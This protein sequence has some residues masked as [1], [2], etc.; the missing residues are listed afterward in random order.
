M[1]HAAQYLPVDPMPLDHQAGC[2]CSISIQGRY[3]KTSTGLLISGP[4]G[5]CIFKTLLEV[6]AQLSLDK[7][8]KRTYAVS[9]VSLL[10]FGLLLNFHFFPSWL[11]YVFYIEVALFGLITTSQFW[12][13]ANLVFSSLEAK[14][15]FGF[16]GAGAIAGGISGGYSPL[17][18]SIFSIVFTFSLLLPP[19]SLSILR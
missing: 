1:V 15:L 19:S 4:G 8:M 13:Q 9:I 18:D 5:S 14:R 16:I 2:Q 17:A 7:M 10:G 3:P 12:L 11:S 6:I